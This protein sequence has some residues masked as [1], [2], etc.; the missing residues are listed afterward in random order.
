[1]IEV[2]E[3]SLCFGLEKLTLYFVFRFFFIVKKR[4]Q[5]S[6][7]PS[8]YVHLLLYQRIRI[9]LCPIPRT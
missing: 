9:E 5:H 3:P 1:M 7:V 2:C 8:C 4:L 6:E